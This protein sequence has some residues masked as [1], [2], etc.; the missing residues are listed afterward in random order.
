MVGTVQNFCVE[1]VADNNTERGIPLD[2]SLCNK[3][4]DDMICDNCGSSDISIEYSLYSDKLYLECTHCGYTSSRQPPKILSDYRK[5]INL[6]TV[7]ANNKTLLTWSDIAHNWMERAKD[8]IVKS[9][10]REKHGQIEKRL[11]SKSEK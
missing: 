8:E 10:N 6:H 11:R 3:K 5:V 9:L 1:S 2:T 7:A 4:R